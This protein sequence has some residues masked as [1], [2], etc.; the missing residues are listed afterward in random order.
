MFPAQAAAAGSHTFPRAL[1]K[2]LAAQT[3]PCAPVQAP[4]GAGLQEGEAE[5]MYTPLHNLVFAG[6]SMPFTL[7]AQHFFVPTL[8]LRQTS[9]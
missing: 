3:V 6:R 5:G 8:P 1:L 4:Q 9:K 2:S 7:N